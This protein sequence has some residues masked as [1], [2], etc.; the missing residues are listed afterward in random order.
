MQL[1]KHASDL[2]IYVALIQLDPTGT[3]L[4]SYTPVIYGCNDK[5]SIILE[6]RAL[7][8]P[9]LGKPSCSVKIVCLSI[10]TCAQGVWQQVV[11][12]LCP[13]C[14]A[15]SLSPHCLWQ[16]DEHIELKLI[17]VPNPLG[18]KILGEF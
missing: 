6:L 18:N 2:L 16:I 12:A 15:L 17:L 13:S 3:C 10:K 4:H 7:Q 14:L 11:K 9:G 8:H 5:P 1:Y